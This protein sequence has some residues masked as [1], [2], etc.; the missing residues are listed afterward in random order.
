MKRLLYILLF[1][2]FAVNAQ[3]RVLPD[4]KPMT[5]P[6]FRDSYENLV[7]GVDSTAFDVYYATNTF[8]LGNTGVTIA[9][10]DTSAS[11]GDTIRFYITGSAQPAADTSLS[12]SIDT[13]LKV[14][15]SGVV[16][17]SITLS[18]GEIF[19]WSGGQDFDISQVIYTTPSA[20]TTLTISSPNSDTLTYAV[21][22]FPSPANG[23]VSDSAAIRWDTVAI[24]TLV[25]DGFQVYLGDTS[26]ISG[27]F[28]IDMAD[29]LKVYVS[30]F[31]KNDGALGTGT[32]SVP[33]TDSVWIDSTGVVP[34]AMEVPTAY[35]TFDESSGDVLD[36]IGSVDG[37]IQARSRTV[38]G[39]ISTADSL[40]EAD[41]D[42]ISFGDF[43]EFP[44]SMSISFWQKDG[45]TGFPG[46]GVTGKGG[47]LQDGWSAVTF[48]SNHAYI[49][50]YSDF[51]VRTLESTTVVTDG[52]WHH[53]VFTFRHSDS[54]RLY[55]DGVQEAIVIVASDMMFGG[56][57][58]LNVGNEGYGGGFSGV[59][60]EYGI[61]GDYVFTQDDVDYLFNSGSG[62][63]PPFSESI[64]VPVFIFLILIYLGTMTKFKEMKKLHPILLAL[65]LLFVLFGLSAQ[66]YQKANIFIQDSMKLGTFVNSVWM[67]TITA[68]SIV[69]TVGG[70]PYTMDGNPEYIAMDS[71][72][73]FS[74]SAHD[75]DTA[76]VDTAIGFD[77]EA[78]NYQ[79]RYLQGLSYPTISTG[80]LALSSPDST[81]F[82]DLKIAIE[83]F[84]DGV[85]YAF[86]LF[87]EFGESSVFNSDTTSLDSIGDEL[88][89][90]Y[91]VSNDGNDVDDG[92]TPAT[93]WKTITKVVAEKG[94]FIAG[95][96]IAFK[97]GDTW[98]EYLDTTLIIDYN[99]SLDDH[100]T[101][102]SYGA[103]AKPKFYGSLPVLGFTAHESLSNVYRC[104]SLIQYNFTTAQVPH[105]FGW[106]GTVSDAFVAMNDT[107]IW[108]DGDTTATLA[109]LDANWEK[110]WQND[111]LYFYYDGNINDVDTIHVPQVDR[112][113]S[114]DA[115]FITI[116]GLDVKYYTY[117]SI[118]TTA[119][120]DDPQDGFNLFNCHL[121]Y[122][123]SV[124]GQGYGCETSHSNLVY[125]NN[126]SHDHG[127][128]N[129]SVYTYGGTTVRDVLIEDNELWNASHAA[130]DI[131]TNNAGD[132]MAN[133]TIRRNHF[134]TP[135]PGEDP[136][137]ISLINNESG[138]QQL[139]SIYMY[140]NIIELG[141]TASTILVW[142]L[143]QN[144]Y[145][146]YNTVTA[147]GGTSG[148]PMAQYAPGLY[149][150]QH[151]TVMNNI[152]YNIS[153]NDVSAY[154]LGASGNLPIFDTIDYN[155][156]YSNYSPWSGS[157]FAYEDPSSSDNY[158]WDDFAIWQGNGYDVN[159]LQEN[160]MFVDS[161]SDLSL[162]VGSPAIE[163]AT[164]I[165]LKGVVISTDYDGNARDAT[166][167]DIGAYEKQSAWIAFILVTLVFINRRNRRK[168]Q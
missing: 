75:K 27:D 56:G 50:F 157:A 51:S 148:S 129:L 71:L 126:Q 20:P 106:A 104:D 114:L 46:D 82:Q 103:G 10:I 117:A 95:D 83:V 14:G 163:A 150:D 154:N 159:G 146:V 168:L 38:T 120:F 47:T 8:R 40:R 12:A 139:D 65:L 4:V 108:M 127:R 96:T 110:R 107:T 92:L 70:L 53:W 34:P 73:V 57:T 77:P 132:T 142:N 58:D 26:N 48:G 93:A 69:I 59:I 165:S 111:S 15:A 81:A 45:S 140:N 61:W 97:R 144:R 2:S 88:V 121:A 63:R 60:D 87:S 160:P 156:Y 119:N 105:I 32:W 43:L 141:T 99:G 52:D 22:I 31:A 41:G 147:Q 9:E 128:R 133:V 158:N 85:N 42:T 90:D 167:P 44:D 36:Q 162:Q 100:I 137:M 112:G 102:I 86:R 67:D 166:T 76:I 66:T 72:L 11:P 149:T 54:A 89:A 55:V 124:D 37:T 17:D 113:I 153:T 161:I 21:S 116:N 33:I 25:T 123:G 136:A 13:S 7:S 143:G 109:G 84:D 68:G 152:F 62:Q 138:I 19:W 155:I 94:S 5:K 78:T 125:S 101:F 130:I 1:F 80:T 28:F 24:P 30:A 23:T 135:Y 98:Y 74:V 49:R 164:P 3:Y 79:L 122:T 145:F 35:W 39:V 91:Y 18:G 6:M 16:W 29:S 131:A 115:D 151:Y 64:P 118:A 134:H